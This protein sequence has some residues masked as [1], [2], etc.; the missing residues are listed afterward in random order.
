ME[1]WVQTCRLE[2]LDR[3][4]SW[5]HGHLLHALHEVESFYNVRRPHPALHSAAALHPLTRPIIVPAQI[6]H[7]KVNRHARLGGIL[8]DYTHAA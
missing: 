4:L 7:L 3:T 2:L 6:D 8:H 1:R 5:N